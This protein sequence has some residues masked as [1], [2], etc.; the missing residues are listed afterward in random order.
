MKKKILISVV[1]I[2]ALI[3][4]V[5]YATES[6]LAPTTDASTLQAMPLVGEENSELTPTTDANTL[7]DTKLVKD[8]ETNSEDYVIPEEWR[9]DASEDVAIEDTATNVM[10]DD[11]QSEDVLE[12]KNKGVDGNAFYAGKE[13]IMNNVDISGD[14][15]IAA[16]KLTLKNVYISG[17]IY[18]AGK[19][20]TLE[21]NNITGNAYLAS[22]TITLIGTT[23]QDVFSASESLVINSNSYIRRTI[24]AGAS[25]I[26]LSDST[27]GRHMNIATSNLVIGENARVT[28]SLNYSAE[29][30]ASIA[31]NAT[32]GKVNFKQI[33]ENDEEAPK[34]D[35]SSIIYSIISTMVYSA[36]VC[37]F[38]VLFAKGFVEKQKVENVVAHIA[39]NTGIGLLLAIVVPII[40]ILLMCTGVGVGFALLVLVLYFVV[41]SISS[42]LVAVS[43]T[44]AVTRKTEFSK[45][46]F[47]GITLLVS[48]MIAILS[49]IPVLGAFVSIVVTLAGMGLVFSGLK[50]K[51][52]KKEVEPTVEA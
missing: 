21:E 46:K 47:Y 11:F 24:N 37:G 4:S 15:F 38:I 27:I 3:S 33:T 18:A 23:V 49:K 51:K 42:P 28:G 10:S 39:K 22:G 13:I 36:L 50:A 52:E 34:T 12:I 19:D 6:N 9:R 40:S 48:L 17:N 2:V 43:I 41:F 14:L 44:A 7:Q 32:I 25:S 45:L 20:I 5:V 16:E 1:L 30:E 31:P 29:Q 35:I 8:T 26:N